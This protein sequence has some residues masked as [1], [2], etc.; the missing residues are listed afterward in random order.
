MVH[1]FPFEWGVPLHSEIMVRKK[2][3]SLF[4]QNDFRMKREPPFKGE[5]MNHG[6][7]R[8]GGSLFNLKSWCEK[9]DRYQDEPD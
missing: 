5:P 1:W 6:G 8:K 9:D 4:L 7:S 2:K 3:V